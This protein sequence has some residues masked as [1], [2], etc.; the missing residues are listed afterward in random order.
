MTK[1]T[2]ATPAHPFYPLRILIAARFKELR[3]RKFSSASRLGGLLWTGGQQRLGDARNH[4]K[5]SLVHFVSWLCQNRAHKRT[6]CLVR[7]SLVFRVSSISAMRRLVTCIAAFYARNRIPGGKLLSRC[8]SWR[9]TLFSCRCSR[10]CQ[11]TRRQHRLCLTPSMPHYAHELTRSGKNCCGALGRATGRREPGS[12]RSA[13]WL[14][15]TGATEALLHKATG[16]QVCSSSFCRCSAKA[17][18]GT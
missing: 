18:P 12:Q 2:A 5:P 11:G 8:L 10:C 17:S 13:S 9:C 15:R 6:Q 14:G 7:I 4:R 16:R 1:H 3:L